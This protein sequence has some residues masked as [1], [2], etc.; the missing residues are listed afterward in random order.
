M[1]GAGRRRVFD[2]VGRQQL[3]V[4]FKVGDALGLSKSVVA[5]MVEVGEME[6]GLEKRIAAQRK[7]PPLLLRSRVFVTQQMHGSALGLDW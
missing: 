5:S 3:F 1:D 4:C 2:G 6:E 7:G